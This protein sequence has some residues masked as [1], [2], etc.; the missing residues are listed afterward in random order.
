MWSGRLCADAL[1]MFRHYL[2]DIIV[3]LP[4]RQEE[5][6]WRSHVTSK[7]E[8]RVYDPRIGPQDLLGSER[9]R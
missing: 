6:R 5:I 3:T 1:E 9:G 2:H 7:A 8:L 4:R